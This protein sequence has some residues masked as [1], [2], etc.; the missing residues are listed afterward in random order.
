MKVR[1][2]FVSNSSSSSFICDVCGEIFSGYDNSLS[3]FDLVMCEEDHVFCYHHILKPEGQHL[4]P[5]LTGM[6]NYL[7]EQEYE[8]IRYITKAI[9][10]G[11][12]I[13]EYK[14]QIIFDYQEYSNEK[15][16]SAQCPVCTLQVVQPHILLEYIE[17]KY[18]IKRKDYAD[19]I[20]NNFTNLEALLKT[21]KQ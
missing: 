4:V 19:E 15:I 20:R 8:D 14:E 21:L 7:T 6:L 17:Y 2:G 1:K 11:E 10:A 18:G 9:K 12:S 13:T 16:L 3:D 5:I